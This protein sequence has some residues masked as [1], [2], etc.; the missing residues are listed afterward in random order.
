[1]SAIRRLIEF[2]AIQV[3]IIWAWRGRPVTLVKRT[4]VVLAVSAISFVIMVRV[5]PG[6]S[7]TSP[8]DALPAVVVM[9]LFNALV[10]PIVLAIVAPVS[11][12]LTS[13]VA[14]VLQVLVFAP[15]AGIAPGVHIDGA[16]TF[17]QAAVLYAVL[18]TVLTAVLDV[19]HGG[20]YYG[21]LVQTMRA[22]G[23]AKRSDEPGLVVVQIDGLAH[24]ILAERMRA[25]SV[26]TMTGWVRSGSHH[27][28]RWQATLPTMTSAGQA[29]I[30]HGNAD[31]IPAFRWFERDRQTMMVS[32]RPADAA[33]IVRR[34]SDGHGLL[35]N[36]G[37]SIS[38]LLTG[39]ATRSYLTTAALVDATRGL[40]D[41]TAYQSFFLSPSGYVRTITLF[42]AEFVKERVQAL[43]ADRSGVE[44][45][46]HRDLR[47]ALM[48]A[49][50]NV[51]LR[52][53]NVS[54]V[55][56]EM[57]RGANVIY[58][59]FVD[60]DEIAHHS[61]PERVE[62]F[63]ALDG[64]DGAI[65]TIVKAAD[66][67]PRPYRFVVLSD[68]GQSFGATFRQRYG[69][70]LADVVLRLLGEDRPIEG[71]AAV[72]EGRSVVNV[73]LSEIIRG[74]SR[75]MRVARRALADRTTDGVVDLDRPSRSGAP[76]D[77]RSIV[78]L[79]SGNLGLVYFTGHPERITL[80][81]LEA[82]HPGLVAALA[83]HDGIGVVAVRSANGGGLAVGARGVHHLADGQ[84]DGE[85][86]LRIYGPKVAA[87]LSRV[88]AMV[89]A[90][91][92]L[93]LSRHDPELGEVAAFEELIGSHGGLGG[94]QSDAFILHPVDWTL[95]AE[96]P[97]G[98]VAVHQNLRRWLASIGIELGQQGR[99]P[100]T[101]EPGSAP[102]TG[103]SGSGPIDGGVLRRDE[104]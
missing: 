87:E 27:L 67:A 30:L 70:S 81:A 22:R 63:D 69:E 78:V 92:L 44:P 97:F 68:H 59:D 76:P 6:I 3:R 8:F 93:L 91:D 52:D 15:I 7:M 100:G 46:L 20:S 80:E 47:Y 35:S 4:V 99:T 25:G 62:A 41:S 10:R 43:R 49:T 82:A 33:E 98:P 60:Y 86:P 1:M 18:N 36:D 95:D 83:D 102:A 21:T 31:G 13:I 90:P 9:A 45:R 42:V 84:I 72:G 40:G 58:V 23:S 38:N 55:I 34:I 75:R 89:H 11:V 12:I 26:Q 101:M 39:D 57:Y 54:L 50:S 66:G 85:D 77:P 28:G 56:E 74:R 88:D 2:Y 103:G 17:V 24:P 65:G 96:V 71:T 51:V 48:R 32:S 14:L 19:D 73:L 53:L 94:P 79:G 64:V 16:A 37:V 104:D 61:G 29:G 5:L